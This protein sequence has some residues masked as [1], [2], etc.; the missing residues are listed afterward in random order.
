MVGLGTKKREFVRGDTGVDGKLAKRSRGRS[1]AR[2]GRFNL[3]RALTR[4]LKA[5]DQ[6]FESGSGFDWATAEALAF[7][8]LLLDGH[9]VRLAG[10]DSERG[11]FSQRHSAWIDQETERR[12]KPLKYIRDEQALFEVINSM[13]S[14]NAVLGFEYGYSLA[15]PNTLVYGRRNS[16]ILPMAHKWWSINLS[17]RA[18]INGCVCRVWSCCC[19]MVMRGKARAQFGAA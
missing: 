14:E 15:E 9:P 11:T 2:A 18:K 3:H 7:G 12:Y 10:Q 5:K 4:Q 8:S 17:H 1:D 19:R 16:A 13:L 6:M